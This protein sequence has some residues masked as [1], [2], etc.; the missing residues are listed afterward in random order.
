M[1]SS[2]ITGGHDQNTEFPTTG[3]LL[4]D[5][6]N[7]VGEDPWDRHLPGLLDSLERLERSQIEGEEYVRNMLLS[8][9]DTPEFL[10]F[11]ERLNP[12]LRNKVKDF[13]AG[14]SAEEVAGD[15]FIPPLGATRPL[16]SPEVLR[17]AQVSTLL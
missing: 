6:N 13:M 1:S 17:E 8:I 2:N 12:T 15:D 9:K 14:K 7:V 4:R 10:D 3:E 11:L 16:F 5:G